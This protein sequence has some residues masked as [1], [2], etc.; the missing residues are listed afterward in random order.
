[1]VVDLAQFFL[2]P[3]HSIEDDD[4]SLTQKLQQNLTELAARPNSFYKELGPLKS[5]QLVRQSTQ[6]GERVRS[7]RAV[8]QN[9]E[10]IQ[11]FTLTAS[12]DIAEVS[13]SFE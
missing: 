9:S 11:T 4:P 10:L 5:F 12:G 7:Y 2:P 6:D 13:V 1:M 8:F 3:P